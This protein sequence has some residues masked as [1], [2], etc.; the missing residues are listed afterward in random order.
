MRRFLSAL[1][2]LALSVPVATAGAADP[3]TG[4]VSADSP[5]VAWSGT[6]IRPYATHL[7]F[8]EEPEPGSYP[9]DPPGCD[10]FTLE[11]ADSADLAI[12][13]QS[14][15]TEDMSLRILKPDGSWTYQP[16]WGDGQ[17]ATTFRLKKA[18]AGKYTVDVTARVFGTGNPTA[19]DDTA[20]YKGTATLAIVKPAPVV[21]P[22]V[23]PA[24]APAPAPAASKPKRQSA[25][26]D[27][28]KKA[29]KIRSAKKRRAAMKR[30]A[31][32]R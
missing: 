10:S 11:V 15:K 6:L 31:K 3:S 16:G 4:R 2:A 7:A 8:A 1:A 32:K 21:A 24:A 12:T 26:A 13:V 9:C 18:A 23:A 27:C 30:C 20:D 5:S 14:D 28:Q 17:K 29:K 19:V 25:R 22:V